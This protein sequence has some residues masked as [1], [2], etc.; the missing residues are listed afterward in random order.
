MALLGTAAKIAGKVL[1]PGGATAAVGGTF[2]V[3]AQL[4]LWTVFFIAFLGVVVFGIGVVGCGIARLFPIVGEKGAVTCGASLAGD[5][6]SLGGIILNLVAAMF[7]FSIHRTILFASEWLKP[8][9]EFGESIAAV[10]TLIRDLVNLAFIGGLIWASISMILRTSEQV[11]KL[12]VQILIAALLVNFSYFFAGAILDASHFSAK[13]IYQEGLGIEAR[14]LGERNRVGTFAQVWQSSGALP[15]RIMDAT[16]LSSLYDLETALDTT[17]DFKEW[18]LLAMIGLVGFF[19]YLG[20]GFILLSAAALFMGRFIVMVIL[21]MTA[22]VGVLAFTDIGNLKQI[23]NA[24]WGA[25]VSQALFPPVFLLLFISAVKV[26]ETASAKIVEG[27]ATFLGLFDGPTLN[28]SGVG[29]AGG[30]SWAAAFEL[31]TVYLIGLGVMWAALKISTNIARQEQFQMPRTGQIYDAYKK[32]SGGVMKGAQ[33]VTGLPGIKQVRDFGYQTG[34]YGDATGQFRRLFSAR[35]RREFAISQGGIQR[36]YESLDEAAAAREQYGEKSS[37]HEAALNKSAAIRRNLSEGQNNQIESEGKLGGK[38]KKEHIDAGTRVEMG[39]PGMGY[40]AGTPRASQAAGAGQVPRTPAET[41]RALAAIAR[42]TEKLNQTQTR[43]Y[44][45]ERSLEILDMVREKQNAQMFVGAL[46]RQST[47]GNNKVAA[48][49]QEVLKHENIAS[50][51]RTTEVTATGQRKDL[52]DDDFAEILVNVE[53][54]VYNEYKTSPAAAK[55]RGAIEKA[56]R[57][58]AQRPAPSSTEDEGGGEEPPLVADPRPS[59]KILE[60]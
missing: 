52:N 53:E 21:L 54:T 39:V 30:G 42:G 3:I 56:D 14:E 37:E 50:L 7:D 35:A 34:W 22:P 18:F 38:R 15:T 5:L 31:I 12:I 10:W 9:G 43:Q 45:A 26:L 58:R 13:I 6:L 2:F 60:K 8:D 16:H 57:L 59:P 40:A 55:R 46:R 49:P 4:I 24:W 41:Q 44:L 32:I 36:Y 23:G 47:K 48:L 20:V 51:L 29:L 33:A 17:N 28:E 27:D 19:L 11:G 1:N 25:L